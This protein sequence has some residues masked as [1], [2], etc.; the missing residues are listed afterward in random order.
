MRFKEISRVFKECLKCVLKEILRTFQVY[1]K[2]VSMKFCFAILLLH[3]THHSYPSRGSACFLC[4]LYFYYLVC[5][6]SHDL[7][8]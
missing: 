5:K 7:L 3:G 2:N 1:L 4:I 6:K 8:E